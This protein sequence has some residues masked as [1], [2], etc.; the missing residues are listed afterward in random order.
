M[1]YQSTEGCYLFLYDKVED[2]PCTEDYLFDNIEDAKDKCKMEYGITGP[3]WSEIPD[4]IPG[5]QDD[6]IS[7]VRVKGR[8]SGNPQWGMFQRLEDEKWI[9]IK[10]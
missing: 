7:P 8:D 2:G 4:P 5:C 10:G 1:L 6:W 3:D 9:D